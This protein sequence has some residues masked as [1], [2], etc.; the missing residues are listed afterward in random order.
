M[1]T[2]LRG[3]KAKVITPLGR[4]VCHHQTSQCV[5]VCFKVGQ[6]NVVKQTTIGKEQR[7]ELS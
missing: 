6:S 3:A 4:H 7:W 2:Y 5:S 1:Q